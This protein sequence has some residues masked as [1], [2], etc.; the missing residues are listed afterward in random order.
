MKR[1]EALCRM[2]GQFWL[3]TKLSEVRVI[4][5]LSVASDVLK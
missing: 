2:I 5:F 4:N 1:A 3:A